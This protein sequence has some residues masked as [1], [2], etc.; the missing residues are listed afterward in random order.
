[1]KISSVAAA[2]AVLPWSLS[3]GA[4]IPTGETPV[5][6]IPAPVETII[7]PEQTARDA[8][9]QAAAKNFVGAFDVPQDNLH[10]YIG[11][12]QNGRVLI[13]RLPPTGPF[14]TFLGNVKSATKI[15]AL[16][17]GGAAAATLTLEFKEGVI[18]VESIEAKGA[19]PMKHTLI[20]DPEIPDLKDFFSRYLPKPP[21]APD[22][23]QNETKQD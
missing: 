21:G 5:P 2:A 9:L 3:L 10:Y 19:A 23:G 11:E 6:P 14:K 17:A 4:E 18:Q 13:Y 15:M 22:A 16:E 8:E 12:I 1:M 20:R 7:P